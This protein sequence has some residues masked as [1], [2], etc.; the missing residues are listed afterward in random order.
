MNKFR[1]AESRRA[2]MLHRYMCAVGFDYSYKKARRSIRKHDRAM[3]DL[4]KNIK[5]G[6]HKGIKRCDYGVSRAVARIA[7]RGIVRTC[8]EPKLDGLRTHIVYI[9]E[10]GPFS[11]EHMGF[12]T[13]KKE[14]S[15]E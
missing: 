11:K 7:E 1:K 13:V 14:A 2:K 3:R 5:R 4:P 6:L 9:D 12:V 15:D 8:D 10:R